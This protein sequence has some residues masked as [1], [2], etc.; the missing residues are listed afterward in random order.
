M[1][2]WYVTPQQEDGA[3]RARYYHLMSRFEAF[4]QTKT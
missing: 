1:L 2:S 3:E 4:K